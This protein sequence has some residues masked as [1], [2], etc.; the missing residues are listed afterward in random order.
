[1]PG[2]VLLLLGSLLIKWRHEYT[3]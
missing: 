1:M 2:Y 3:N